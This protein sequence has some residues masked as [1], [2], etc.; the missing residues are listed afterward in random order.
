[1]PLPPPPSLPSRSTR[2]QTSNRGAM[3]LRR[4]C[5]KISK[6][7]TTRVA[8]RFQNIADPPPNS[9]DHYE[10]EILPGLQ[11]TLTLFTYNGHYPRTT[12]FILHYHLHLITVVHH[13]AGK[14]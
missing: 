13:I 8:R 14:S 10:N 9:D 2:N 12:V 3:R 7:S 11:V 6:S 1:M 4:T 5:W